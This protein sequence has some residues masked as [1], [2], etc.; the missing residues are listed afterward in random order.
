MTTKKPITKSINTEKTDESMT[1]IEQ[2]ADEIAKLVYPP[3]EGEDLGSIPR[4]AVA[5]MIMELALEIK[6]AAIE[7]EW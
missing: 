6:R 3:Q 4:Q 7:G 2:I 5:G 1:K